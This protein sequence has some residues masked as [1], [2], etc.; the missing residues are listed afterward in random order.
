MTTTVANVIA[1]FIA[2]QAAQR[3]AAVKAAKTN[4]D[5]LIAAGVVV[6]EDHEFDNAMRW[7]GARVRGAEVGLRAS[8]MFGVEEEIRTLRNAV[9]ALITIVEDGETRREGG[10]RGEA[11]RVAQPK[12]KRP[13]NGRGCTHPAREVLVF[14]GGRTTCMGCDHTWT[15][16]ARTEPTQAAVNA[17]RT[18][19][20]LLGIEV[21]PA[22]TGY[23]TKF[24]AAMDALFTAERERLIAAALLEPAN[25]L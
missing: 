17:A 8:A 11:A 12:G 5:K 19:T 22:T 13:H 16:P 25:R 6:H 24:R 14:T 9:G 4:L 10:A 15:T 18:L 23:D 2:E 21:G 20:D 1:A 7:E 3:E